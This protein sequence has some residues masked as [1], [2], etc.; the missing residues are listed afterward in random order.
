MERERKGGGVRERGSERGIDSH[1]G[2]EQEEGREV[3]KWSCW[4]GK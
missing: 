1:K 4:N 2:E 3:T